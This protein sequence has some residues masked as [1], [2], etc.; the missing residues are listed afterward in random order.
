MCAATHMSVSSDETCFRVPN[1]CY[2]TCLLTS[3]Q[4]E[5]TKAD[6]QS[7]ECLFRTKINVGNS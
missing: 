4:T 7:E 6:V 2:S 1:T 5:S 3:M